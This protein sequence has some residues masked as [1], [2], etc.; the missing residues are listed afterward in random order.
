MDIIL[1]PEFEEPTWRK[2][3]L[4]S[5]LHLHEERSIILH[6]HL[7]SQQLGAGPP[8]DDR[9]NRIKARAVE[10]MRTWVTGMQAHVN[11][12]RQAEDVFGGHH[13]VEFMW[14]LAKAKGAGS[15]LEVGSGG[16]QTLKM[17]GNVARDGATVHTID[18]DRKPQLNQTVEYLT[19]KGR[20]A[21]FIS[22]AQ[23][24]Q[25]APYDTVFLNQDTARAD[26]RRYGKLGKIVA[27]HNIAREGHEAKE[28]WS[29]I[30]ASGLRTEE[31]V[32][33]QQGIGLVYLD[34]A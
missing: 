12:K 28:L 16:G 23:A 1:S 19:A 25:S 11:E 17:L 29:E 18:W 7:R 27:I 13:P 5:A 15:V 4:V 14:F 30:K 26:W 10:T 6:Q 2:N 34:A 31:K 21:A 32:E 9:Y 8:A 22:S 3:M 20:A 24:Q 33:S